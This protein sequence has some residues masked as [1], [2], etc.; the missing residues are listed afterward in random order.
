M[1]G[2]QRELDSPNSHL[3]ALTCFTSSTAASSS[4]NNSSSTEN[5]QRHPERLLGLGC[6][7]SILEEAH[8][9]ILAVHP[10][11]RRQ[12]FGQALLHALLTIAWQQGLERATLEVRVSNQSALSLYQKLGFREAGR[13]RRYYSDT[14]EDGIIL[15]LG[16]LQQPEFAQ[17]LVQWQQ[18]ID[19]RLS[20]L[21][22][23]IQ[24]SL[25]IATSSS[26]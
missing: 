19:A 1:E 2:Y 3:L 11:Y 22:W 21:K 25:P 20:Q 18:Q 6:L 13:R 26:L 16:G 12:G 17:S 5:T 10:C 14:G 15:W 9:T 8:L 4:P 23:S 24:R 7:W